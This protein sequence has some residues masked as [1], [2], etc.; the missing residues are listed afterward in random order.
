MKLPLTQRGLT[1]MA[2]QMSRSARGQS[3]SVA[4]AAVMSTDL[5]RALARRAPE[6]RRARLKM[7]WREEGAV[8]SN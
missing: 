5:G 3:G 8:V 7:T 4:I 2:R 1:F 6:R